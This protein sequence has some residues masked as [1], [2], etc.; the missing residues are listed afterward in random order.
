MSTPVDSKNAHKLLLK[1]VDK[2]ANLY[3]LNS[4]CIKLRARNTIE[5]RAAITV[6]KLIGKPSKAKINLKI[7]I[8]IESTIRFESKFSFNTQ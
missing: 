3:P 2:M 5:T 1:L 7:K 6:F 4:Y 8:L